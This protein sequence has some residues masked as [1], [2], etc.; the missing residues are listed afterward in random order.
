MV[1]SHITLD[2]NGMSPVEQKLRGPLEDQLTSAF[3]AAAEKV[4]DEYAGESVEQVGQEILQETRSG[5]H[6]DIAAG[7]EPN[8]AQL[9]A[10][11]DAV[12]QHR[13]G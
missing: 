13:I 10:V 12:V 6:P 2:P 4:Q 9:R 1:D 7:F 8:P 11:A 5:L 3:E